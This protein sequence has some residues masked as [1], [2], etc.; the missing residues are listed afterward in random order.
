MKV[1][2]TVIFSEGYCRLE[3]YYIKRSFVILSDSW[4]FH[5]FVKRMTVLL[6]REE[7][8]EAVPFRQI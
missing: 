2:Y 5:L 8:N 7:E 4:L 1:D 3:Y 6:S